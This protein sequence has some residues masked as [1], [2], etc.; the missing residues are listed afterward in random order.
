MV[1]RVATLIAVSIIAMKSST[2]AWVRGVLLIAL[3]ASSLRSGRLLTFQPST[4]PLARALRRQLALSSRPTSAESRC[5]FSVSS[6][7]GK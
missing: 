6:R 2:F 1:K 5:P 4:L 7:T 3:S